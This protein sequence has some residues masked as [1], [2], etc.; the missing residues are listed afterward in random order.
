MFSR[1][2]LN[3][4]N[5]FCHKSR[6]SGVEKSVKYFVFEDMLD[7][8]EQLIGKRF[9]AG[10]FV[11]V[12]YFLLKKS[13]HIFKKWDKNYLGCFSTLKTGIEMTFEDFSFS[14]RNFSEFTLLTEAVE[15]ESGDIYTFTLAN[16][17]DL[18]ETLNEE[19]PVR[20]SIFADEVKSASLPEK[21]IKDPYVV[22]LLK[23]ALKGHGKAI[24]RLESFLN[25][26]N[27]SILL[28][29]VRTSPENF[30]ET[31][32]IHTS[33]NR[34]IILGKV[35]SSSQLQL[36]SYT[37]FK[38]VVEAEGINLTV[39]TDGK[40][41]KGDRIKITG[42]MTGFYPEKSHPLSVPD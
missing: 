13:R 31:A 37:F 11:F 30:L 23:L 7:T 32:I 21:P 2:F 17:C 22:R 35:I 19:V 20:I 10:D 27:T 9:D 34:Y 12:T 18:P 4:E 38:S 25:I 41:S 24:S 26:E 6:Q 15:V 14:V 40:L 29:K 1:L 42:R 16:V 39:I 36:D 8:N 5:L 33:K 28:K 3:S